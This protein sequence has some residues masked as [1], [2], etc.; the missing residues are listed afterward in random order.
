MLS[1]NICQPEIINISQ[2]IRLGKYDGN[3]LIGLP[4]YQYFIV[5]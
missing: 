5:A 3:Y 2:N 1:L 4:W